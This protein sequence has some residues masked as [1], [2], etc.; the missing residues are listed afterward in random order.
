V[1][2]LSGILI[3]ATATTVRAQDDNDPIPGPPP[4]VAPRT[5]WVAPFGDANQTWQYCSPEEPFLTL[6]QARLQIRAY[7]AHSISYNTPHWITV[8]VAGG[9]YVLEDTLVF[10]SDDSGWAT[11]PIRYIAWDPDGAGTEFDCDPI[12]MGGSRVTGWQMEAV[13]GVD[14]NGN[15]LQ[16]WQTT[17]PPGAV[18]PRDLYYNARRLIPARYPN[19]PPICWPESWEDPMDPPCPNSGVLKVSEVVRFEDTGLQRWQRL[20]LERT[21]SDPWPSSIDWTEVE[22]VARRQWEAPRQIATAGREESTEEVTIDFLVTSWQGQDLGAVEMTC[23][24]TVPPSIREFA[25]QNWPTSSS[26]RN[27]WF[28]PPQISNWD[29][30]YD[31]YLPFTSLFGQCHLRDDRPDSYELVPNYN[32]TVAQAIAAE[33]GPGERV[34][35]FP[36]TGE[37]IYPLQRR[38]GVRCDLNDRGTPINDDPGANDDLNWYWP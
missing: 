9:E 32:D 29:W 30:Y 16:L 36:F 11:R 5:F 24:T 23:D 1:A 2:L 15:T 4:E 28:D 12:V 18:H 31:R 26:Q 38:C 19:V 6:D 17:L 37:R 8:R 20:V 3:L 14:C 27:R 34:L 10:T 33:A 13:L 35:W 21:G 22:V 25:G 7:R